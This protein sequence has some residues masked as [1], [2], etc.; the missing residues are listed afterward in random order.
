[1]ASLAKHELLGPI[2]VARGLSSCGSQ[3]LEHRLS[4]CGVCSWLLRGVRDL[5]GAGVGPV[6][7]ALAGGLNRW[8][9]KEGLPFRF[10]IFLF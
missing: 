5:P 8:P 1:V 9:A 2:V 7:P 3:A 6:S 10:K 4:S